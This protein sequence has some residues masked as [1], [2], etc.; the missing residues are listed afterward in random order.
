MTFNTL[1]IKYPFKPLLLKLLFFILVVIT[2]QTQAYEKRDPREYFFS[3]TFGDLNEELEL[4]KEEGKQGL[5]LFYEFDNCPY[6]HLMLSKVL[7]EKNVQQWYQENFLSLA[8]D[9]YGDVEITDFDGKVAASKIY[10]DKINIQ[11]TPTII[12][13]DLNGTEIYRRVGSMTKPED[14]LLL[15]KFVKGHYYK[16]M[17]F[18]YFL[19]NL[20]PLFLKKPD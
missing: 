6:C 4:A 10:A 8:I 11:S 2:L 18:Q 15:G 20:P 1:I 17:S 14:F 13:F 12:F 5:L 9:I 16:K 7:N 3:E 19:K